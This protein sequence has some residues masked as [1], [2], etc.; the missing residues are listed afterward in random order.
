MSAADRPHDYDTPWYFEPLGGRRFA[1]SAHVGGGWNPREQHIAP[2]FGLLTHLIERH[3]DQRR[4]DGLV[5]GRLC[6]DIHGV[7]PMAPFEAVFPNLDLTAHLLRA[8]AG[9]WVGFDTSVSFGPDGVGLTH[10]WVHD[11]EGLVGTVSQCLT[12]RPVAAQSGRS[13]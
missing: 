10:S 2:A 9:D 7:L 5:L 12:V 8:P 3:R 6:F 1:P 13:L 4:D 11:R